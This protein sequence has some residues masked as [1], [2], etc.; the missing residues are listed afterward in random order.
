MAKRPQTDGEPD[1]EPQGKKKGGLM[2]HREMATKGMYD[3]KMLPE[4]SKHGH[5]PMRSM[6][7]PRG[8]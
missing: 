1:G 8:A 7:K 5:K 4:T 3:H 2:R 6:K